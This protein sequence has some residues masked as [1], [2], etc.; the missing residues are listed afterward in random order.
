MFQNGGFAAMILPSRGGAH[1]PPLA[2][3]GGAHDA[4][5]FKNVRPKY[6]W[7]RHLRRIVSGRKQLQL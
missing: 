3:R 7:P 1:D 2:L 5:K 6:I 4:P